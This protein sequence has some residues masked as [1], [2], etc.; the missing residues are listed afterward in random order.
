[1]KR[2]AWTTGAALAAAALI[3]WWVFDEGVHSPAFENATDASLAQGG[4]ASRPSLDEAAPFVVAQF[5]IVLLPDGDVS[6]SA[7]SV[8]IGIGVVSQDDARSFTS[9][10]MQGEDGAG[11]A[12]FAE[13][14]EIVRWVDI[15]AHREADGH[16]RVGPISLPIADRY[17]LQAR[18]EHALH[19]Y[20]VSFTATD[21]PESVAPLVAAG[22]RVHHAALESAR[23]RVLLRRTETTASGPE[24]NAL[25]AREAPDLLA[26]FDDTSRP[27]KTDEVLAPLPPGDLNVVLEVNGVEADTQSV[28]LAAGRVVDVYF[29]AV[30]Q[31]VS[32]AVAVDLH[33]TFVETHSRAPIDA[34][35]V[36]WHGDRGDQTQVTNKAGQANFADVD[37]QK[38]QRFS[39]TFPASS[40][41]LPRWPEYTAIEVDLEDGEAEV[42]N[43]DPRV[44]QVIELPALRWLIVDTGPMIVPTTRQGS[45]PYPAFVLQRQV[46]DGWIDTAADYFT[47]TPQGLAVSVTRDGEYRVRAYASPWSASASSVADTRARSVDG[48]YT[49]ALKPQNGR[50]VELALTHDGLPLSG[51]PVT[52]IGGARGLPSLAR[53][54]DSLGRLSLRDVSEQSVLIEVPGFQQAS[55]ALGGARA[56]VEVTLDSE[57]TQA[58]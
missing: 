51:A 54:T 26:A 41:A 7:D 39:L 37:R 2:R 29:D 30:A 1:V 4:T 58:E 56:A 5:Q 27:I 43:R 42:S 52:F 53:T 45:E 23:T 31:E 8:R 36:D 47:P 35:L 57:A 14:A 11:P 55:V 15:P 3:G 50:T 28:T 25:L 40:D 21:I 12:S 19:F 10:V 9:W 13:L 46:D 48:R 24:W 18:G 44:D 38:K 22:V 16:V 20:A 17:D 33:L 32:Q 49:I 34:L 6:A